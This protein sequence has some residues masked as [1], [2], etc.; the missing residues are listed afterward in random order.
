MMSQMP[1]RILI[2]LAPVFELRGNDFEETSFIRTIFLHFA[3]T[4]Q[5]RQLRGTP[6]TATIND[7]DLPREKFRRFSNLKNAGETSFEVEAG[8][9]EIII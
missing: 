9:N 7:I 1:I 5:P 4:S 2:P 8:A 3:A 6:R